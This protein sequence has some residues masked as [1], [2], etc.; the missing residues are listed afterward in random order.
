MSETQNYDDR[1]KL[2]QR[3]D[4]KKL[5]EE[6]RNIC[7]GSF[8]QYD[9][10]PLRSLA[11]MV[12]SSQPVP[13][14]AEDYADGSW[15]PWLDTPAL[16]SSDYL[17]EVIDTFRRH[18]TVTLVRLIRLAPKSEVDKHVDPCLGLEIERSVIRLTVPIFSD[19]SVEFY[20]NDRIVPM[21]PGECWY[22][23]LSDPHR[24]VNAGPNERI[25]MTIDLQPNAWLL[26]QIPDGSRGEMPMQ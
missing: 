4:V 21:Q 9:V 3:F 7:Q 5:Q 2:P 6:A 11:F 8:I 14:P 22:M 25:N 10:V 26:S 1:I 16:E 19:E 18:C 12:D 20:L 23:R 15:T 24:V 17:T 13:P